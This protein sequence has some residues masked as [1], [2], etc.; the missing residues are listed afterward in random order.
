M[1]DKKTSQ[2]Q[3]EATPMTST[4]RYIGSTETATLIRGALKSR[5]PGVKFSVK[6]DKYSGGSSIRIKWT[7]GPTDS[8]V[9]AV[10]GQYQ[11]GRFDGMI[12][13]AYSVDHWLSP[14]GTVT[15]ARD[16]GTTGSGGCHEGTVTEAPAGA[17]KVHF[18]ANHVFTNREL[19]VALKSR[20]LAK[21][22]GKF[23]FGDVDVS[24]VEV[25]TTSYGTPTLSRDPY[26]PSWNCYLSDMV[27]KDASGRCDAKFMA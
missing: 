7:D 10:V 24:D 17:V 13:L 5:F 6:T 8:M 22:K 27:R 14:D 4:T 21:V 1:W 26:I 11:G 19:S 12:D 2:R 3:T 9:S 15:L 25:I 16:P 20:A 23:H 18:C